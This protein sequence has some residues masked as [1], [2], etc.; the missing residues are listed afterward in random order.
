VNAAPGT[1]LGG[2]FQAHFPLALSPAALAVARG[3]STLILAGAAM[4]WARPR[5]GADGLGEAYLLITFVVVLAYSFG[6]TWYADNFMQRAFIPVMPFAMA[7]ALRALEGWRRTQ[8][9]LVFLGTT[10]HVHGALIVLVLLWIPPTVPKSYF[11][12]FDAIKRLTP[13]DT[14]LMTTENHMITLYTDRYC[15]TIPNYSGGVGANPRTATPRELVAAMHRRHVRYLVGLPVYE[16]GEVHDR[17]IAL[18]NQLIFQAP[19]LL[20]EVWMGPLRKFALWEVDPR[21]LEALNR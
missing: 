21:G 16:W 20:R 15:E 11:Q 17:S 5:E 8:A 7:A 13:A 2:W 18:V 4:G 3:I 14:V 10:S 12:V 6:F 1:L 9:G 19:G